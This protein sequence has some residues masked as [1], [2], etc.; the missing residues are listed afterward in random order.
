MH[1]ILLGHFQKSA[2][3]P[4]VCR[5]AIRLCPAEGRATS[6]FEGST[7]RPGQYRFEGYD[8]YSILEQAA[9][10]DDEALKVA[11]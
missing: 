7:V 9:R 8:L 11:A 2:G 5:Y 4:W 6:L 1:Q 10:L 3:G